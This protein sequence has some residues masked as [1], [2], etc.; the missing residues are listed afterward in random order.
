MEIRGLKVVK[1]IWQE[2]LNVF[3]III[4]NDD[5]SGFNPKALDQRGR[6]AKAMD[7]VSLRLLFFFLFLSLWARYFDLYPS[8]IFSLLSALVFHWLLSNKEK[9]QR[10]IINEKRMQ[11]TAKKYIFNKIMKMDLNGEFKIF[12]TQILNGIKGFSKMQINN[13]L[14]SKNIDIIGI[15]N[16]APIAVNCRKYDEKKEISQEELKVFATAIKSV[17]IRQGIFITTSSFSDWA[18]DYAHSINDKGIKIILADKTKLLEWVKL[19]KHKIC[20]TTNEIKEIELQENKKNK[21]LSLRKKELRYKKLVKSFFLAAVYLTIL[22]FLMQNWLT[23][24]LLKIYFYLAAINI[25]LGFGSYYLYTRIKEN[26]LEIST[27]KIN[28]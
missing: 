27:L 20:P 19:S 8:I 6:L 11:V 21:L 10:E 17:G 28:N 18:I 22:S 3:E 13:S 12:I 14:N 24:W 1:F 16:N 9:K 26:I 4:S 2:L 23:Y 5:N 15:Y 7:F 25:S